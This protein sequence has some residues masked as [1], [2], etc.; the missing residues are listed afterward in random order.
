VEGDGNCFYRSLDILAN[1]YLARV[2][3][4]V[5]LNPADDNVML[6][7]VGILRDWLADRVQQDLDS[8][9]RGHFTRYAAFIHIPDGVLPSEA[10]RRVV[11][12]IRQDG[13]WQNQATDIIPNV[14]AI[15]LGLPMRVI[16]QDN[17]VPLGRGGPPY[18]NF[19]R[20]PGHYLGARATEGPPVDWAEL[21][22]LPENAA[23]NAVEEFN[24]R[25][26]AANQQYRN[27]RS[28]LSE[29]LNRLPD[30]VRSGYQNEFDAALARFAQF[31]ADVGHVDIPPHTRAQH[32]LDGMNAAVRDI[33]Q[34]IER[35]KREHPGV[36]LSETITSPTAAGAGTGRVAETSGEGGADGHDSFDEKE[37]S[38]AQEAQAGQDAVVFSTARSELQQQFDATSSELSEY[39]NRLGADVGAGYL[40]RLQAAQN[41]FRDNADERSALS[42][43]LRITEMRKAIN[44][45]RDIINDLL[46]EHP[47][48]TGG[49]SGS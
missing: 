2:I 18:V 49:S 28:N 1:P 19:V 11:A 22:P 36:A 34:I 10:F 14:A 4:N 31:H 8:A 12:G 9:L 13:E 47:G 3:N 45:I 25:R 48:V 20:R 43:E 35:L 27:A 38:A 44:A 46:A 33:N 15:E 42:E 39:L 16:Q 23:Q 32:R 17:I 41:N 5:V 21:T 24:G 29:L 37:A 26:T 6:Y 30:T 40:T 7:N